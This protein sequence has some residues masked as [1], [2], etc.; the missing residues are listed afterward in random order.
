MKNT[1]INIYILGFVWMDILI[2][3]RYMPRSG[4]AISYGNSTFNFLRY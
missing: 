2:S 4:I 1:A 3:L